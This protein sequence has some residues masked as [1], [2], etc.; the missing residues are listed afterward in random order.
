MKST[1]IANSNIAIVKYWGKRDEE[2]ILPTNSSLSFTMDEQLSTKTTVEFVDG[3]GQ[4]ELYLDGTKATEK[5]TSRV[6]E[7]LDLIRAKAKIKTNA[8]VISKNTFPKAAGMASSA[9][10]FAA[11]AGAASKAAGLNL[12]PAEISI[13]ARQGSGSAIRSVY[14]GAVKWEMGKK[15]D[16]SDSVA[17]QVAKKGHWPEIRNV[18][19]LITKK[20]KKV[21]SRSGMAD[22]LRTSSLYGARIAHVHDRLKIAEEAILKKDFH[23]LAEVMMRESNNMHSVML[24][25]WPP[26]VY[27]NDTAKAVIESVIEFNAKNGKNVIAYTYDAGPNPHLYTTAQYENDAKEILRSNGINETILCKVGDDLKFVQDHLK[28]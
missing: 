18:I 22:T 26:I 25:T 11:L 16:G 27:M 21:S 12:S 24:D 4:D 15:K 6:S 8:K 20:E 13:L 10:A 17:V 14:G 28:E 7:F 23:T 3:S 2:L 5:E 19:G 1:A 9:S